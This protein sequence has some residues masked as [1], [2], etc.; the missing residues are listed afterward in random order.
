M[1]LELHR[2]RA[3][4]SFFLVGKSGRPDGGGGSGR[5]GQVPGSITV[6]CCRCTH[7]ALFPEQPV[8]S[9]PFRSHSDTRT[10]GL[11]PLSCLHITHIH[12]LSPS[13]SPLSLSAHIHTLSLSAHIHLSLSQK[14]ERVPAC[15]S[16][17]CEAVTPATTWHNETLHG[18]EPCAWIRRGS[19]QIGCIL[20]L[21]AIAGQ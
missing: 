7:I 4:P 18:L 1:K 8:S 5:A 13:H 17:I 11:L 16:S 20:A 2:T 14:E 19:V 3:L 15:L 9:N 6:S 21:P 10:H 12:T